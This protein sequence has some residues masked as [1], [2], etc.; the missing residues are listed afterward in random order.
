MRYS[1]FGLLHLSAWFLLASNLGCAQAVDVRTP[2]K[3]GPSTSDVGRDGG[4]DAG[5]EPRMDD[6]SVAV[7]AAVGTDA[8]SVEVDAG[9][10]TSC[11]GVGAASDGVVTTTACTVTADCPGLRQICRAGLCYE[12]IVHPGARPSRVVP[13]LTPGDALPLNR[14]PDPQ[15]EWRIC[16]FSDTP[17]LLYPTRDACGV[18]PRDLFSSDAGGNDGNFA[19]ICVGDVVTVAH[20]DNN[21]RY[22]GLDL[23]TYEV[24]AIAECGTPPLQSYQA[25]VRRGTDNFMVGFDALT[26]LGVGDTASRRRV[27]WRNTS[28]PVEKRHDLFVVGEQ[29]PL[30]RQDGARAHVEWVTITAM[31][32]DGWPANFTGPNPATTITYLSGIQST[33]MC[34]LF[35]PYC[36]GDPIDR[37]S[38]SGRTGGMRI[39]GV[40][41]GGRPDVVVGKAEL[42]TLLVR[43]DANWTAG[44][45][46]A[47]DGHFYAEVEFAL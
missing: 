34:T 20:Y 1:S 47:D 7:D 19:D 2:I 12:Q 24:I 23:G 22:R 3:D 30:Y 9:A 26:M 16:S 21:R 33:R 11:Q 5:P 43:C 45:L 44:C 32:A 18:C 29:V 39:R 28:A 15:E 35:E 25:R 8:A 38:D 36:V 41:V 37:V 46:P 14:W 40:V 13:P 31:T 4:A 6:A 10:A 42:E 27:S 17:Q